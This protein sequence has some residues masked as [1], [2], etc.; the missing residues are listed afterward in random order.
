M[1]FYKLTKCP[2]SRC[3][4]SNPKSWRF[5]GGRDTPPAHQALILNS[6][7]ALGG[8]I[9]WG[10]ITKI[11]FK[12][13]DRVFVCRLLLADRATSYVTTWLFLRNENTLKGCWVVA[14]WFPQCKSRSWTCDDQEWQFL[15]TTEPDRQA[16]ETWMESRTSLDR[17]SSLRRQGPLTSHSHP[18]DCRSIPFT[19]CPCIITAYRLVLPTYQTKVTEPLPPLNQGHGSQTKATKG[20]FVK[21]NWHPHNTKLNFP[22]LFMKGFLPRFNCFIHKKKPATLHQK[23]CS[24]LAKVSFLGL[25]CVV[26]FVYNIW[27]GSLTFTMNN[28][29]LGTIHEGLCSQGNRAYC[30]FCCS[31]FPAE[32]FLWD[33]YS[34]IFCMLWNHH[35][36]G[37]LVMGWVFVHKSLCPLAN[38]LPSLW[39][40]CIA[41]WNLSHL[42]LVGE[43]AK[44]VISLC[45][46]W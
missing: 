44:W 11:L 4:N 26:Y 6:N 40:T 22:F 35:Q 29:I 46:L 33:F 3:S 24:R 27:F 8:G 10:S 2:S 17:V 20:S 5:D 21:R 13:T 14:F 15:V 34:C 1:Q 18:N 7:V 12:L 36:K 25:S 45:L 19:E 32:F 42:I 28:N 31:I 9:W 39:L 30:S 23:L 38:L 43:V 41:M 16:I 37:I